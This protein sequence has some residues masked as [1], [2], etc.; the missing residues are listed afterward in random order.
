MLH[1]EFISKSRE[2][3]DF[4]AK[5]AIYLTARV[6]IADRRFPEAHKILSK[7]IDN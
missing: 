6:F 1:L 4:L 3:N 5:N 2:D 7:G